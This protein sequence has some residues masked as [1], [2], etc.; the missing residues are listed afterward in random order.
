MWNKPTS[1][2]C[3]GDTFTKQKWTD[4]SSAKTKNFKE[5]KQEKVKELLA[6]WA[7]QLNIQSGRATDEVKEGA[8]MF[9]S[10]LR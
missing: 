7:G 5:T 4:L 9:A 2:R 8:K 6:L 10:A 3:T 1:R